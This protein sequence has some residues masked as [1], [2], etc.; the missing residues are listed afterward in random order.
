MELTKLFRLQNGSKR[1]R[2]PVL[3]NSSLTVF[4]TEVFVTEVFV[5]EVFV[6]EVFVTEVSQQHQ[7]KEICVQI[8]AS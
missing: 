6:T 2:T 5:T 1:I 4:V 7:F 3:L 8:F